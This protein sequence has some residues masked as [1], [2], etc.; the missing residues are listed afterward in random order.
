MIFFFGK[1]F[2][3]VCV[4]TNTHGPVHIYQLLYLI[5]FFSGFII[6]IYIGCHNV[7]CLCGIL[8]GVKN[9]FE[10]TELI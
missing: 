2:L 6:S 3:P 7:V 8:H 1:G 9:H 10:E 5:I 4:R